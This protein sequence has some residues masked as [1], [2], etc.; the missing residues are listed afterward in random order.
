[1]MIIVIAASSSTYT[2]LCALLIHNGARILITS[3]L[4]DLYIV[5]TLKME[6]V[7]QNTIFGLKMMVKSGLEKIILKSLHDGRYCIC[8]FGHFYDVREEFQKYFL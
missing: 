8:D 5:F 2:P 7:S 1:M 6:S 3:Y 4:T